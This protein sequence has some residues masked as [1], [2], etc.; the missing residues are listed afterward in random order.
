MSGTDFSLFERHP[1]ATYGGVLDS[2]DI[3]RVLSEHNLML[4]PTYCGV[5]GYPGSIPEVFQCG[6]P[7]V[8]ARRG[9]VCELVEHE[10]SGLLV[11]PR[12]ATALRSAIKR[13]LEDSA[14]YRRLCAG[15]KRRGERFRSKNW[16]DRAA[17]DLHS[18][19]RSRKIG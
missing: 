18:L 1:R 9:G 5:E 8:A 7:V 6:L 14:M 12:S 19:R 16:Y 17:A 3:H 2:A 11:D 4:F 15:A 10:E 13:L